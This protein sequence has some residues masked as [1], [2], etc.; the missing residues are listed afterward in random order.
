MSFMDS[1][2]ILTEAQIDTIL[3]SLERSGRADL[4]NKIRGNKKA[5]KLA[6]DLQKTVDDSNKRAEK[7]EKVF[8]KKFKRFSIA[9]YF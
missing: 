7:M 3:Q 6:I 2:N 5:E 9:D 4:A 8:K 1:K